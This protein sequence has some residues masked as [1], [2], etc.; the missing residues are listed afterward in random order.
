MPAT[1]SVFPQILRGTIQFQSTNKQKLQFTDC[2]Q[3][4]I[5]LE[6]KYAAISSAMHKTADLARVRHFIR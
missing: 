5:R 3:K 6:Q 4:S 2:P 1:P